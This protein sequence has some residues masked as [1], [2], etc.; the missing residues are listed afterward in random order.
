MKSSIDELKIVIN[1]IV[2]ISDLAWKDFE[3][4]TTKKRI[5]KGELL[6]EE[7]QVC[8]NLVF[9][10]TGLVRSYS[11]RDGKEITHTF[12]EDKSLFYDDYSFLTQKP[13]K[14]TFEALEDCDLL[15][16]NR[17]DLFSLY[18]EYKCFER[19]G[20]RAV[21]I[22]HINMIEDIERLILG[23]AEQNYLYIINNT[24]K[25]IQQVPLKIIATYLNI[26]SEH[27]SRIRAKISKS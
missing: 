13:C 16:V 22:A 17:E 9:L 24:P 23:S 21:E 25:L 11:F 3:A 10:Q 18:D 6:W 5:K 27:L 8:R 1:N 14:K 4:T 15:V 20:R 12:Y 19:L 7:G 2:K 26:S